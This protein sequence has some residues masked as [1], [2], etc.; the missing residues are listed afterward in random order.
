NVPRKALLRF[1]CRGPS[2]RRVPPPPSPPVSASRRASTL[3]TN[4]HNLFR[5]AGCGSDLEAETRPADPGNAAFTLGGGG[6]QFAGYGVA[7]LPEHIL[8]RARYAL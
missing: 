7:S 5:I 4:A 3:A 1:P 8:D 6:F 2:T